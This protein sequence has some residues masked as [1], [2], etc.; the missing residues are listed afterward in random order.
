[1]CRMFRTI[2]PTYKIRSIQVV[3]NQPEKRAV[4]NTSK[5]AQKNALQMRSTLLNLWRDMR[6]MG[7]VSAA[8]RIQSNT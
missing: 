4:S 2:Q 1:M 5:K 7:N 3:S 8:A 6:D